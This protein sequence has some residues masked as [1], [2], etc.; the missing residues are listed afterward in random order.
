MKMTQKWKRAQKYIGLQNDLPWL[1]QYMQLFTLT[2]TERMNLDRKW[3]ASLNPEIETHMFIRKICGIG[4]KSKTTFGMQRQQMC[5]FTQWQKH[6]KGGG[7][8][9]WETTTKVPYH[10]PA[11]SSVFKEFSNYFFDN[12]LILINLLLW[13]RILRYIYKINDKSMHSCSNCHRKQFELE[14]LKNE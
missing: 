12:F 11:R 6:G 4:K 1:P 10:I 9:G 13:F 7:A 8:D 2:T 3:C 14:C 5:S